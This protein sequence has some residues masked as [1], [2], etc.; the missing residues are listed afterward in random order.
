MKYKKHKLILDNGVVIEGSDRN[1]VYQKLL[2][3]VLIGAKYTY[4][5]REKLLDKAVELIWE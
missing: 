2:E 3:E 1:E 5:E 4:E